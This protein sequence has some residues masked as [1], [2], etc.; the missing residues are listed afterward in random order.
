M[1]YEQALAYWTSRINYE[2]R[3]PAGDELKLEPMRTLLDLLGNPQQRLRIIHVAGS[4][5]KGS[6]CALLASILRHANYRTGLFTSPHLSQIEERIQVDGQPLSRDELT[7]LLNEIRSVLDSAAGRR[8]QPTF[9]EMATAL[10]FLHFARRQVD[11]AVIEVGLGG[12]LD[13]TNVCDPVLAVITS[14]SF[15]HT[16]QLGNTLASIARE[17]AG[18]IKPGRP[19]VS[20]VTVPEARN[21]IRQISR[22]REAPLQELGV[23][24]KYRHDP[25]MISAECVRPPRIQVTMPLHAGPIMELGLLGKHQAAN[26]AVAVAAVEQLR[27]AGWQISPAAVAFGLAGVCWPARIEVVGSR[28]FVVLDCAHNVASVE[29][30]VTTLHE[31]FPPG[32]RLLVFACSR[33]YDVPGMIRALRGHFAHAFLTRYANNPRGVPVEELARVFAE[34]GLPYTASP[35]ASEAWIMAR[36]AARSEDLICVTG[37]VFLAGELRPVLLQ[38]NLSGT[39]SH[40]DQLRNDQP[41][42]AEYE[43]SL[44]R[45][46]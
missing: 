42:N 29:A 17:K 21:V 12:R 23:D 44:K 7:S 31:S 39:M 3:A 40:E 33:D 16:R 5:G 13:S 30:L 37:S 11:A 43:H 15:A 32:R 27:H 19:V 6:T 1:D 4:K 45:G 28:P 35:V 38:D 2:E 8:I 26:A 25:G 10:G 9:F 34:E 14:I 41:S 36:A 22:E 20:G 18:I 46:K 24:F